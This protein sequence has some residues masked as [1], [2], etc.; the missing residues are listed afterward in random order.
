MP[1]EKAVHLNGTMPVNVSLYDYTRQIAREAAWTVIAEH[2][3]TCPIGAM[4]T[5]VDALSQ[6]VYLMLG[7]AAGGGVLGGGVGAAVMKFL[8]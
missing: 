3:K 5:K 2:V 7:A 6:K 8:G 1:D 4:Q